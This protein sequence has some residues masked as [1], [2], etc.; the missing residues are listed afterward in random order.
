[1]LVILYKFPQLVVWWTCASITNPL[2]KRRKNVWTF[3][4]FLQYVRV[5]WLYIINGKFIFLVWS[6]L[7]LFVCLFVRV[8]FARVFTIQNVNGH[9]VRKGSVGCYGFGKS[10]K[11]KC[12]MKIQPVGFKTRLLFVFCFNIIITQWKKLFRFFVFHTM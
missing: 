7:F 6:F 10:C 3:K 2:P 11:W 5:C 1:M 12:W 9:W 8:I 4:F